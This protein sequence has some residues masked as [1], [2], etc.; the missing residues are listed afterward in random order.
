MDLIKSNEYK[1][2]E[3]FNNNEHIIKYWYNRDQQWVRAHTTTIE[4][5]YPGYILDW[6][7]ESHYCWAKFKH[8]PGKTAHEFEHT[9]KFIK[10]LI[11]YCLEQNKDIAPYS[12]GDWV[13]SNILYDGSDFYI[14]DW[15]NIGLYDESFVLDKMYSDL[16][17]TLG[18][19][20]S[21]NWYKVI[22]GQVNNE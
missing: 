5:V 20:L 10:N 22:K 14:C 19:R 2:R 13:L 4:R 16:Y 8:L 18:E 11:L 1:R 3:V 21:R 12:H 15:D 6:G 9:D 7:A 17:A